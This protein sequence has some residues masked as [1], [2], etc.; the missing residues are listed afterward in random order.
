MVKIEVQCDLPHCE[1]RRIGTP[2][3]LPYCSTNQIFIQAKF[4]DILGKE[5][6]FALYLIICCQSK[7]DCST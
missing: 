4:C 3:N 7:A 6:A 1:M 5:S 2:K